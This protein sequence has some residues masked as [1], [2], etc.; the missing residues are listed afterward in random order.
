MIVNADDF[1]Y[2]RGVNA[3]IIRGFRDGIVTSTTMMANG[4]AFDDAVE[5]A[6]ENPKLGVGC[7]LMLVDGVA[8]ETPSAIPSLADREGNL[9]ATVGSLAAKLLAGAVRREDIARELRAQITKV[10]NAGITPTHLDSHKHTHSHPKV[11]EQMVK[12]AS[13]FGI[14]CIRKPFEGAGSLV[15]SAFADGWSSFRQSTKALLARTAEPQFQKVARN[16]GMRMPEHFWGV[17]ATGHLNRESILSMLE[18]M[19]EG[20]NELMCHP[21]QCDDEL[22]HSRTRLKR[23]R[24]VELEALTHP[25]VRAAIERQGIKLMDYRGLN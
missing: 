11:M 22:K 7:H 4:R 12:V 6:K 24:E 9:P 2:T 25:E 18:S 3:G 17:A 19:P 1:G 20:V 15:K 16:H 23:E 14:H 5:Y 10:L 8:V 13:E 21:G